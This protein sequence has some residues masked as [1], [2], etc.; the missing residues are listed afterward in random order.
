MPN[1]CCYVHE[2]DDKRP[3]LKGVAAGLVAI[4]GALKQESQMRQYRSYLDALDGLVGSCSPT[5]AGG[6]KRCG[7]V[8]EQH[9]AAQQGFG[10]V[11][12]REAC[13]GEKS[14]KVRGQ[15]PFS[16]MPKFY[17][18]WSDQHPWS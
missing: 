11:N 3:F 2:H 17:D 5:A 6:P 15:Q 18:V 9:N 10:E 4:H 13:K 7:I 1:Q 8:Q 12:Q 16:R 14:R